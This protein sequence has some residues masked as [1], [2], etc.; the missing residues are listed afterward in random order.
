MKCP[1]CGES[2][3]HEGAEFCPNCGEPIY[4]KGK[5]RGVYDTDIGGNDEKNGSDVFTDTGEQDTEVVATK[6]SK[7]TLEYVLTLIAFILTIVGILISIINFNY[8]Y[9]AHI[10]LA[11]LS[12][13]IGL[14]GAIIIRY[15]P[16]IGAIFSII[17]GFLVFLTNI[18]LIILI[19]LFYAVSAVLCY[20]RN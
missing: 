19:I 10:S 3:R 9:N 6:S 2:L 14:I 18:P 4:S 11:L 17:A 20:A 13:I 1:S 8:Y 16:R 15:F 5:N 12:A 7:H